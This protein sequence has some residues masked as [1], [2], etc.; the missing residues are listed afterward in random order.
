MEKIKKLVWRTH[1]FRFVFSLIFVFAIGLVYD[2]L[3]GTE[4][5]D[6]FETALV[7]SVAYLAASL[8][9]GIINWLNTMLYAWL[10]GTK[11]LEDVLL[12]VMRTGP[13][14]S[15]FSTKRLDYLVDIA[16]DSYGEDYSMDD[17]LKAA[18]LYGSLTAQ[19][20]H[21]NFIQQIWFTMAADAAAQRFANEAPTRRYEDE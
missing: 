13:P 9:L 2:K 4:Y 14:P 3:F 7:F 6:G 17:R 12:E 16:N 15:E 8:I 19:A 21:G 20:T 1:L 10:F 5:S 18:T 11:Q